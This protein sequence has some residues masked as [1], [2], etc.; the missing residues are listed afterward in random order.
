MANNV[1]FLKAGKIRGLVLS[2][3]FLAILLSGFL[4]SIVKLPSKAGVTKADLLR[5]CEGE[6]SLAEFLLYFEEEFNSLFSSQE[7]SLDVF[8]LAQRMLGKHETRNFEVLKANDG[9]LY[10]HGTEG[11]VDKER[12]QMIADEY[13][14]LYNVTNNYGGH[15]LYVQVPYKNVGQALE[16]RDYSMDITEENEDYLVQLMLEKGVPLIDLRDYNECV[17]YYKTDHHWTTEAAFN[18]SA[19]IAN[20][21]E[22]FY[23]VDLTG[24]EYYGNIENYDSIT[25]K[26]CFLGSI[27]IKVGPY[28]SGRDDFTVYKPKFETDINF[29]HYKEELHFEYSGEFWETFIDQALLEDSN[30]NN[31]YDANMHSAYVESI[32]NNNKSQNDYK[33]LLITHSYGRAMAQYMCLNYSELRY[34]DP[35]SGRYEG[36]LVEYIKEYQ[37]DIVIVM[38]NNVLNVGDEK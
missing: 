4:F 17:Q 15:F 28:F 20:E 19:I 12:L 10:L 18:A 26:N 8:S 16:L 34:L 24:H 14:L 27:G 38:Y 25:Y 9:A 21:I 23:G 5:V 3:L 30:Y 11:A 1:K 36:N 31:K 33:G 37:P 7:C 2:F 6:S 13:E 29:K 35:Q 32:I 22:K